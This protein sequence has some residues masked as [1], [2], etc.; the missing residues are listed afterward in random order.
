MM[1]AS[2]SGDRPKDL[3]SSMASLVS[4]EQGQSR[5]QEGSVWRERLESAYAVPIMEMPRR[6]LSSK[7]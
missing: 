6:R 1:D 5:S 4:S 3:P 2:S 7:C